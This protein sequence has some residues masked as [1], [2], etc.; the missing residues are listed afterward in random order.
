[1]LASVHLVDCGPRLVVKTA[2]RGR[3][4]R[5]V[6]GLR[7]G[8]VTLTAALG[9]RLLPEPTRGRLG[10]F[11]YWESEEALEEF[12]AANPVAR[13]F[14]AGWHLRLQPTRIVGGWPQID[15]S[16]LGSS[17]MDDGEPAAALTLGLLRPSQAPRFLRA[18][19]R[20]EG[21]ALKSP[22]LV[23]STGFAR[24]PRLV[25]TFSVWKT[26]AAMRSYV[27]GAHGGA[28]RDAVRA[29]AERPFHRESAFIRFRLLGVKGDPSAWPG[30][31]ELEPALAGA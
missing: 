16:A 30:L 1:M 13:T 12:L 25:S 24:P 2:R 14:A 11:A 3:E 27:E 7:Y 28:H 22:G 23:A 10:M 5:R 21:L 8:E 17:A 19:A 6:T 31:S 9:P 18:S 26:T 20:A 29:H 4:L 15:E